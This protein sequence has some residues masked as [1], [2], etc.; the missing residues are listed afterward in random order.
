MNDETRN[1]L[2]KLTEFLML[3]WNDPRGARGGDVDDVLLELREIRLLLSELVQVT[4]ILDKTD[5]VGTYRALMENVIHDP[6]ESWRRHESEMARRIVELELS[7][8]ALRASLLNPDGTE[9]GVAP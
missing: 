8:R 1:E 5:H 9:E 6:R 7:N 3:P 2:Q 4:I